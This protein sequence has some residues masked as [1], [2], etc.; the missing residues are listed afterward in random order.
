MKL[1]SYLPLWET[2]TKPLIL[3]EFIQFP[4][5]LIRKGMSELPWPPWKMIFPGW[6]GEIG[7]GTRSMSRT[8]SPPGDLAKPRDDPVTNGLESLCRCRV[9]TGLSSWEVNQRT[10]LPI[11]SKPNGPE[12]TSIRNKYV[13]IPVK[14]R[15]T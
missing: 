11:I 7:H 15:M 9:G 12:A 13:A 10:T 6:S 5:E 14:G 3:S 8:K 4:E 1:S 2:L